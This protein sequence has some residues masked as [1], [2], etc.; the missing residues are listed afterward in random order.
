MVYIPDVTLFYYPNFN[1]NLSSY[2]FQLK[3]TK[4]NYFAYLGLW[5]KLQ[6][7]ISKWSQ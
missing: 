1:G 6:G 5:G 2:I 7:H 3:R 4:E